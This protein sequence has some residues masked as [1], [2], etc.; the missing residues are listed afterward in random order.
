M[1]ESPVHCYDARPKLPAAEHFDGTSS[2]PGTNLFGQ[3]SLS[4]VV[5]VRNTSCIVVASSSLIWELQTILMEP[6][7]RRMSVVRIAL[8]VVA[9][10]GN[11]CWIRFSPI[12]PGSRRH[13]LLL[14]K[15]GAVLVRGRPRRFSPLFFSEHNY[16]EMQTNV[17]A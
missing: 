13:R 12:I 8:C 17:V 10:R 9:N 1:R 4:L 11:I 2:E 15:G 16:T 3:T 7:L 6:S 14:V 5:V